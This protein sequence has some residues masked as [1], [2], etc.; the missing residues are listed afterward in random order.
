MNS[1]S[2][3][4]DSPETCRVCVTA[5]P[6]WLVVLD[7]APTLTLFVLGGLLLGHLSWLLAAGY[8][9]YCG[10][11]VVLF[12][13]RIC[14]HCHHYGQ[15]SC[16]CGYGVLAARFFARRS[17]GNFRRVFR[18]NIGIMFPCWFVPPLGA[19]YLL[20]TEYTRGLLYGTLAFCGIGF[21]L[22]PLISKLVGCKHCDLKEECPWMKPTV[23]A[24]E[25]PAKP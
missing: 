21:V 19:V 23:K 10:L 22:I 16:R 2:P 4:P 25:S 5:A 8:W 1:S 14:T 18:R 15:A 7:N 13:R 11:A 6:A 20:W 12:W 9:A 3:L 17:A 24:T